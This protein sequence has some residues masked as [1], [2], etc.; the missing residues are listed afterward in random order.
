MTIT[1]RPATGDDAYALW[2]WANDAETRKRSGDRQPIAWADHVAWLQS[3]LPADGALVFVAVDGD[4]QPVG[5]IRFETTDAWRRARLSYVVAPEARGAGYGRTLLQEGLLALARVRP[6]TAIDA[7]VWP[8]NSR[9]LHLFRSLGWPETETD[10]GTA[11]FTS[12]AGGT[13]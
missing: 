3:R 4:G 2:V 11:L 8:G 6:A 12:E 10:R 7:E 13:S 9:S 1:L 5:S